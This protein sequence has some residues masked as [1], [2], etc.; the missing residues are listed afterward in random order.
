MGSL[1]S[2]LL[3]TYVGLI[4]AGFTVI[5]LLAGRQ[6]SA[7]T[8]DDYQNQL[9]EQARIVANALRDPAEEA[10]DGE[11]ST[12]ALRSLLETYAQ[13]TG[14]AVAL[15]DRRGTFLLGTAAVLPEESGGPEV[16]A[17]AAGRPAG[18]SRPN[19]LGVTTAYAAAPITED[20]RVIAIVQLAAPL[21][22]AESLVIERWLTLGAA[23]AGVTLVAGLA[24]VFL[25]TTLSRPL[26][27]LREAALAMAGGDFSRRIPQARSDEIGALGQA[28]NHMAGQVEGMLEE[29]RA[30]AA[31]ASHELRTP[32]TTIRLRSEALRQQSIDPAT[33]AR[34][35]AEI[36]DEA[37]R[38]GTLV[39]DLMLLS[40]LDAGRL[41]AGSERIDT[42]RLAQRLLA[43]FQPQAAAQGITLDLQAA[44]GLPPVVAGLTHLTIVFRNLLSNALKYTPPG[45]RIVWEINRQG[46]EIRHVIRDSGQG[47]AAEDLPRVFERFYRADR[48][49]TRAAGGTG[50]GLALAR[51]IVAHYGATIRVASPGIGQGTVV[52]VRWPL[53]SADTAQVLRP[54]RP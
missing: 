46:N 50:L 20:G 14:A 11:I 12:A 49:R 1:R 21:T 52:E 27:E 47:I 48:A 26:T 31:N 35:V 29:Q 9:V 10:E 53:A 13:Q 30:F 39:D 33:A 2:R 15:L 25:S 44:D 8:V 38:M 16:T 42:V 51:S 43:Q 34:Y 41:E 18:D 37:A 23:V 54:A 4:L 6:I 22:A 3:L 28:F 32:L 5:A 45:G 7:G 40:R 19:S 36:D 17:A 24:A